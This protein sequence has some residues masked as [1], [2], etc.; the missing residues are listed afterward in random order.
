[1]RILNSPDAAVAA[2]AHG[3]HIF[4]GTAA[5]GKT[6]LVKKGFSSSGTRPEGYMSPLA[7]L[8]LAQAAVAPQDLPLFFE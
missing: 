8:A 4:A 3:C 2:R 6:A 7:A 5:P 1:L